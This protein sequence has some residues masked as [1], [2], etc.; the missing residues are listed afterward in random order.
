MAAAAVQIPPPPIVGFDKNA[1]VFIAEIKVPNLPDAPGGGQV[2]NV[3]VFVLNSTE[4]INLQLYIQSGLK[5]PRSQDLFASTFPKAAFDTYLGKDPGLYDGLKSQL[6]VIHEHCSDFQG[7]TVGPMINIGGYISNF[8]E[9]AEGYHKKLVDGITVISSPHTKKGDPQVEDARASVRNALRKLISHSESTQAECVSLGQQLSQFKTVTGTDQRIIKELSKRFTDNI[10]SQTEREKTLNS[11]L[12]QTQ[13]ALKAIKDQ[14]EATHNEAIEAGRDKWY[15][16]VPYLGACIL[17]YDRIRQRGLLNTLNDLNK[18][19]KDEEAKGYNEEVQLTLAFSQVNSLS[20]ALG[21]VEKTIQGAID[22]VG[23]MQ[24]AFSELAS[25]FKRLGDRLRDVDG[26][27]DETGME[28]RVGIE[29]LKG[30]RDTWA[31]VQVHAK[32]FQMYGVVLAA[33]DNLLD[34]KS[35]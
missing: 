8:A 29:D 3:P 33:N 13:I 31:S 9:D 20:G 32:T 17:I 21:D 24:L 26:D 16:Y 14:A 19:Y 18:R 28:A 11:M 22:A 12:M 35:G 1:N 34:A 6:P 15:Y 5:L 4:F 2:K 10:P 23:K 25:G 30:A 27:I 7:R